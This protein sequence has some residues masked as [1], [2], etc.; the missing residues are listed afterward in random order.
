MENKAV[1]KALNRVRTQMN[2]VSASTKMH[3]HK[4]EKTLVK[5]NQTAFLPKS[6]CKTQFKTARVRYLIFFSSQV[7]CNVT[8]DVES[9]FPSCLQGVRLAQNAHFYHILHHV[10]NINYNYICDLTCK[11]SNEASLDKILQT[12]VTAF[13]AK[14][15]IWALGAGLFLQKE[16]S[17]LIKSYSAKH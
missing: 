2:K 4:L 1:A 7:A 14:G 16:L 15:P 3:H 13:Q 5:K 8:Q 17:K 9:M 12:E 6:C 11:L 10:R